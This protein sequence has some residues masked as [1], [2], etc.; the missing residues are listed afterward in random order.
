[1]SAFQTGIWTKGLERSI[2]SH[3]IIDETKKSK[4][5]FQAQ[6]ST[7]EDTEEEDIP[8]LQSRNSRHGRLAVN[9]A[10]SHRPA[11]PF[12]SCSDSDD[13]ETSGD[14]KSTRRH[15]GASII[16]LL[17]ELAISPRQ[18]P[19]HPGQD[20]EPLSLE[21]SKDIFKELLKPRK[22]RLDE[23]STKLCEKYGQCDS[24][25]IGKG[26]T[27]CVRLLVVR[28]PEGE[29]VYAVK[30]FRKRRRDELHKDYIKR[31]ASEFCISSSLR[32]HHVV[33]TL[34]LVVDEKHT[35][36]EIM[37]Y[38]SGGTLWDVLKESKLCTD[39]I[40]CCF[41]QLIDGVAYIHSM[42]VAHR[43]LKPENI[44]FD[45]QGQLK[46][47]DFGTSDV[48]RT[49]FESVPHLS[50]GVCGSLPYIAPE[51]FESREYRGTEVDIWSTGIIYYAMKY[52]ALPWRHA[53]PSDSGYKHFL[54]HRCGQYCAIDNLEPGCRKLMNGILEPDPSV[55]LSGEQI[56]CD[57]WF[58]KI[59]VC[60][61]LKCADGKQHHHLL[62]KE[63]KRSK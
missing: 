58:K 41:K 31:M 56:L 23:P 2:P 37:E 11:S 16:K 7:D 10:K 49:A 15:S 43:D 21:A 12:S 24:R 36:C 53:V 54:Q 4:H 47:S 34:D 20:I 52:N 33:E 42:G 45:A 57:P 19:L 26:A 55:R 6:E 1:M 13:S 8:P 59:T 25:I 30:E 9:L 38:C 60:D 32:H 3:R 18:K 51:E 48:F 17:K 50:R 46:I 22:P 29:R 63:T 62:K 44:L 40:N 39:D 35:W 61:Q 28:K 14:Q 5:V 27:S